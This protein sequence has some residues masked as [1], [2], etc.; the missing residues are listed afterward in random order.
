LS[1]LLLLLPTQGAKKISFAQFNEALAM[2]AADKGVSTAD[3]VAAIEHCGGPAFNTACTPPTAYGV[4]STLTVTPDA[5][6][7][8]DA[9]AHSPLVTRHSRVSQDV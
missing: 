2:I 6:R 1:L 4:A 8:Q 9:A 5:M 7:Y 3:V